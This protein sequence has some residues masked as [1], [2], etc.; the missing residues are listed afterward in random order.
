MISS[1]LMVPDNLNF[2]GGIDTFESAFLLKILGDDIC[3]PVVND[4][5][6]IY[7]NGN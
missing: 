3:N 5:T 4:E 1:I 2:V 7:G 6:T